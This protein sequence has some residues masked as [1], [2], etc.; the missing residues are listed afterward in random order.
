M[1]DKEAIEKAKSELNTA[2]YLLDCS[3]SPGIRAINR[4]R[5]DWLSILIWL[6]EKEYERRGTNDR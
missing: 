5:S 6:A 3:K 4:E 2:I 1:T